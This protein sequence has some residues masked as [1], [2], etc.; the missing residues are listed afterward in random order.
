MNQFIDYANHVGLDQYGLDWVKN[1]VGAELKKQELKT[2]EV[3]HII[4]WLASDN[5]PSRIVRMSYDQARNSSEKWVKS[6]IKKGS[7]IKELPDDTETILDFGDGFRIVKL[8]GENAYKREG[9]LMRHCVA[10][11]Y[12]RDTEVY[13]LRDVDNLPHATMEKN[14]Q[15]KGK[16]NG[17]I[18]PKY[19]DYIVKFLEHVGMTVGDS[20][21]EHLG[22]INVKK[23]KKF[24]KNNLF[25]GDYLFKNEEI[26]AIDDC[27]IFHNLND[28]TNQFFKQ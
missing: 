10:S 13:S 7:A 3:E 11:Y 23:S 27:I 15:I 24:I 4:D 17:D 2:E 25:R 21:M 1:V 12:D 22:Y 8:V 9:F 18:H 19:V 26:K 20:E 14:K 6:Q 5:R 16:G 28:F